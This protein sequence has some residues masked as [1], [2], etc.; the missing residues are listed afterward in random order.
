MGFIISIL[1]LGIIIFV[2]ELGHFLVAKFFNVPIREFSIGMGKR[3]FS[4]IKNNTRYSLKIFPFGGSCAM[5]GEDISGSGD[6]TDIG[7]KIDDE[8]GT[9]EFDGVVYSLDCVNKNNFSV[10]SPIKK[11]LICLA[12]PMFNFILA[13]ICAI[14][15]MSISGTS[16]AV[17]N[18]VN[19]N[20]SAYNAKPYALMTGDVI[21][22]MVISGDDEKVIFDKDVVIFMN[23]HNDDFIENPNL[24]LTIER[25]GKIL[26]T[27]LTFDTNAN[28][29]RA[30]MG[31]TLGAKYIPKNV[32][33]LFYYS[34]NEVMFY[35]KL[36]IKSLK[37]LMNG[38][39][40]ANDI[41]GPVGTVAIMGSAINSA[42]DNILNYI[43][44]MMSLIVLISSNLGVMNLLPIPA[45]DG[46]RIIEAT[47]E[48][49]IGKP[50]DERIIAVLNGI[51][52]ILLLLLM[53]Y[54]FGMDIYKL[55]TGA[56][57]F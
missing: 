36:T 30:V 8:K 56:F 50:L 27:L 5:V 21:K 42:S 33:D 38:K 10:I 46:G 23:I 47:I 28:L 31:I 12:G 34:Y 1:I 45:L 39:A 20:S 53:A 2:H 11:I 49:I 57:N 24:G 48:M 40:S 9:I 29:D 17:V 54:V 44:T 51:T 41:S 6:F 19:E 15:I 7:G 25:D 26:N 13:F 4:V 32:F 37:L 16:L 55:F 43:L 35:I 22:E 52:M 18:T 3:I 14:V